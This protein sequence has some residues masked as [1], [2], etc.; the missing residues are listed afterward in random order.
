[1]LIFMPSWPMLNNGYIDA[2]VRPSPK[3]SIFGCLLDTRG[4]NAR[5]F[6]VLDSTGFWAMRLGSYCYVTPFRRKK[7]SYILRFSFRELFSCLLRFPNF[8]ESLLS[9]ENRGYDLTARLLLEHPWL[10]RYTMQ[11]SVGDIKVPLPN[12]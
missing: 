10:A 6:L 3:A 4:K 2:G 12:N 1:M 8:A 9:I 7:I 11:V 5:P